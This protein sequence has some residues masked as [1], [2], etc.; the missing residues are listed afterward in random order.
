MVPHHIQ[1]VM[2]ADMALSTSKDAQVLALARAIKGGQ[3]P[4]IA[5]MKSSTPS[6]AVGKAVAIHAS[7]I[8]KGRTQSQ[9]LV[10]SAVAAQSIG[11]AIIHSQDDAHDARVLLGVVAGK[12]VIPEGHAGNAIEF[13]L[14]MALFERIAEA[15]RE[16]VRMPGWKK[17][18]YL[19]RAFPVRWGWA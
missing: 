9:Q 14:S 1:A 2:M 17:T 16:R 8:A 4:E 19:L 15:F 5:T 18:A 6:T 7:V 13:G 11:H 10:R 3:D 12:I